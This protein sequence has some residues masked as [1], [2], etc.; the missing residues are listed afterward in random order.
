VLAALVLATIAIS[1][2]ESTTR[3]HRNGDMYLGFGLPVVWAFVIAGLIALR[4]RP[5]NRTGVLMIAIGFSWLTSAFTDS[6]NDAVFTLGMLLS[7]IWPGLMLHLLLSYPSGMLDRRSKIV[8]LAGYADTL[9]VSLLLTPFSQPRSDGLGASPRS[10]D[11]LLLVSHQPGLIA[12]VQV[13]AFAVALA[14]LAAS[15]VVLW[16]RW[17]AAAPASRRVLAPMYVTGATAIGVTLLVVA[18]LQIAGVVGNM[19]TFYCFC[20]SFTSIPVGYLFG[21]LRTRLDRGSAVQTLVAALRDQRATGGLREALRVALADPTLEVVYRRPGTDEYLDANGA[22]VELPAGG[23][24]RVT[25]EIEHDGEV[26]A[27][28][29]H[30]PVPPDETGL[31]DAVCGPAAMAIE[32]ERLQADLRAQIQEVSASERRLRDV[33]E[34]VHLLAVSL[35]LDGRI[36]FANQHLADVT[37]WRRE[38]LVGSTWL[39]RF[40]TGDPHF[41]ARVHEERILVHDEMPLVTRSGEVRSISWSNTL[42]RDAAGRI[43][44]ATSI[45]EDVTDRSRGVHQE[46]ALRRLATMVAG[47]ASRDEIFAAVCEEVARLLGGQTGNLIRFGDRPGTGTVVAGWSEQAGIPMPIGSELAFDGPTAITEVVRTGRPARID[48]YAGLGGELA[49]RLRGLGVHSSVAAPVAADNRLWG[50][51]IVSTKGDAI[52]ARDA[53]ARIGQFA[54]VVALCLSS[55]EARAQL[56]A[57]RARIVAA[58]DAERRRLERNLH[59]GA[60]Q[61]LVALSLALRMARAT[62]AADHPAAELLDSAGDELMQ[63]LEELRE[64]ARGIH[65]AVLSDQG[66]RAAL[67]ALTGRSPVPVH[68]DVE[69]GSELPP[70]VEAAA[71][72]VVAESLTNIAKYARAS[73]VEVVVRSDDVGARVEVRDDGVGG[74]DPA[75]GTGLRGLA[76]RVDALGGLLHVSSPAGEGTTVTAELSLATPDPEPLAS[77]LGVAD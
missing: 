33:L 30:A 22:Q 10:A 76:D 32:N 48:D 15:L 20:I 73:L 77:P 7:N 21:I 44:G 50:A 38:E 28:L 63:A 37:G 43:V 17:R 61:R 23:G 49:E 18:V 12:V 19:I 14:A 59:D 16:Q 2:V 36:T 68:L 24:D 40:P 26:V 6:R 56:A 39:E 11:N 65:P 47:A 54:E 66:L 42:D 1:Q 70:P 60:Q 34:N 71:Y 35:D 55:T 8:V 52:L 69:L 29:V 46:E 41:L 51:I 25:T 53:E 3:I 58:G 62:V 72:Y 57:S 5:G 27:V 13:V 67:G 74:A 9:G 64:L 31:I 4:R 75:A 45:G